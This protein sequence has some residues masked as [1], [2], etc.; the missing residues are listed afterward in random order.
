MIAGENFF[1]V[2]RII[3]KDKN[4]HVEHVHA[5]WREALEATLPGLR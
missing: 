2:E 3:G 5:S 4:A 1:A